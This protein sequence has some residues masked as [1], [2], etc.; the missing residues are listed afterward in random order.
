MGTTIDVV[1]GVVGAAV[2]DGARVVVTGTVVAVVTGA[3]VVAGRAVVVVTALGTKSVTVAPRL[4]TT[5]ASGS[6]SAT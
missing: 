4:M 1:G 3:A 5:P 2:V 6:W